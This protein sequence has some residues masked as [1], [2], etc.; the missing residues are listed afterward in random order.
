MNP[1][2]DNAGCLATKAPIGIRHE[3]QRAEQVCPIQGTSCHQVG[4]AESYHLIFKPYSQNRK[5]NT[6]PA[7]ISIVVVEAYEMERLDAT[8]T[9]PDS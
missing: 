8:T 2:M 1:G 9:Y 5:M 4:Q 6:I 3:T 7:L